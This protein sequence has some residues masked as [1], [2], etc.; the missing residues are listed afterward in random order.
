MTVAPVVKSTQAARRRGCGMAEHDA[1]ER[2]D[3]HAAGGVLRRRWRIMLPFLLIPIAALAFSLNEEKRY[4]A[5][6]SL[7]FSDTEK[8]ASA[9]PD[10]EAATN[11]Q[12]LFTDDIGRGVEA[13]LADKGGIAE[14][15][16][17]TQEGTSNVLKISATDPDAQRAADTANAYADEYAAFRQATARRK[18]VQELRFV[19]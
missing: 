16:G 3:L 18:I 19:Q 1:V 5:A 9:E 6:A 17:A 13:R 4:T 8:I 7:L 12:L 15:V 14:H 2:P 11:E 10:R